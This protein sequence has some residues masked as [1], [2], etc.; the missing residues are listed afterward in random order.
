MASLRSISLLVIGV[1]I[2]VT[3]AW[4]YRGIEL[5]RGK[6][7][8]AAH[9]Y[10]RAAKCLTPFSGWHDPAAEAALGTMYAN[11]LGVKE[12]DA[13]AF[14][15]ATKSA[16]TGLAYAETLLGTLYEQG[17]GTPTDNTQ[18]AFWFRQ[19]AIQGDA[20]AETKLGEAYVQG[21]GVGQDYAEAANLFQQAADQAD[22]AAQNDLGRLYQIGLG[23]PRDAGQAANWFEK[24]AFLGNLDAQVNLGILYH[25]GVGVP[26]DDAQAV[27]LF[28]AV[29]AT[30]NPVAEYYLGL[31][32]A[33]GDGV[34]ADP[35]Q[36]V[37]WL[38]RAA[39]QGDPAAQTALGQV[40]ERPG[41]MDAVL[42]YM[43][44]DL[45][46]GQGNATA[47]AAKAA[48]GGELTPAQLARAEADA[49]QWSVNAPLPVTSVEDRAPQLVLGLKAPPAVVQA[50]QIWFSRA[51]TLAGQRWEAVF[52]ARPGRTCGGC[53]AAIG[54]ATFQL[55]GAGAVVASTG[56]GY[57]TTYGTG[58]A[59]PVDDQAAAPDSNSR[60]AVVVQPLAPDR[61][62]VL[63]PLVTI[64]PRESLS[65]YEVFGFALHGSAA[66]DLGTWTDLGRIT[67]GGEYVA[68]GIASGNCAADPGQ[69]AAACASWQGV[70][71]VTPAADGAW[72]DIAVKASGTVL[73]V[74]RNAQAAPDEIYH[75][76]GKGYALVPAATLRKA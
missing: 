38:K 76:N 53:G 62:A 56:Q 34:G 12:D 40:F 63:V 67:T 42:A 2:L 3:G 48:L 27:K 29:A 13:A 39:I 45:A 5:L 74:H 43:L 46:S 47:K 31:A 32:Y 64:G 72:P 14:A 15:L 18:A 23:E 21:I 22:P 59:A 1:A 16:N 36:A 4:A 44:F 20:G 58:G 75:F 6:A 51:F 17:K 65:G 9:D 71:S 24:S 30:G 7:A 33:N 61:L 8:F 55:D 69:A 37:T 70:L 11:G 68:S 25:E 52:V 73:D 49:S 66:A 26:Q 50:S 54:V 10:P 41:T 19:A 57:L 28:K 60:L 35:A